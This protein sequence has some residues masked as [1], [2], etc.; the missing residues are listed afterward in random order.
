MKNVTRFATRILTL[1]LAGWLGTALITPAQATPLAQN[2]VC[3]AAGTATDCNLLISFGPNG[4]ISTSGLGG[5]YD[6]A[7]D[8]LIGVVNNS[9]HTLASF[10]I[11]G[12]NIFGFEGDGINTYLS[13]SPQVA[14]NPD[15]SG[16]GGPLGYFTIVDLNTGTVN[17]W[18]GLADRANTYFSLE[19]GISLTQLPIITN[20]VPEPSALG[21]FGL[22]LIG[23]AWLARR[24]K[25]A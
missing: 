13:P 22:G 4:A 9:G 10:N 3:P 14:G 6:G 7:E 18:G 17:F 16:Y 15:T 21:M 11:S 8:A 24:R 25:S 19:E 5:N 12:F 20:N 23:M 1:A 2:G